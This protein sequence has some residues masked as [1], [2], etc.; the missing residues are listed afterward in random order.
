MQNYSVLETAKTLELRR[1]IEA[2][3]ENMTQDSLVTMRQFAA[4]LQSQQNLPAPRSKSL[5]LM[6]SQKSKE[7][8]NS[9]ITVLADDV[10][11]LTAILKQGYA[12]DALI[13][14]EAAYD[15]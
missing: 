4:F 6:Q 3:L 8:S 13:D 7:V 14:T 10:L 5:S 15:E 12:G 9:W 1:E 11:K 2:I